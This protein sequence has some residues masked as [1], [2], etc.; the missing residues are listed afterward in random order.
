MVDDLTPEQ[1]QGLAALGSEHGLP[2]DLEDN[3]VNALQQ[4]RLIVAGTGWRVAMRVAI[5][6]A[7]A[8]LI[9][10]LGVGTARWLP[11]VSPPVAEVDRQFILLLLEPIDAVLDQA[12]EAERVAEYRAWAGGVAAQ[13][14]L[15]AG[16]KLSDDRQFVGPRLAGEIESASAER[17]TGFFVVRAETLQAAL[18]LARECPHAR[19]GGRIEVREIQPT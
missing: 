4:R 1:L 5:T 9:F 13:G 6:A 15:V 17:V 19:H 7:A 2:A 18:S 3:V 8:M 12:E 14:R 11:T 16:E 10:L